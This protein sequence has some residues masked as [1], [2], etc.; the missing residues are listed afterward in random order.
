M[1]KRSDGRYCKQIIIGY[2]DDG[3]R[4]LKNIYGKTK[5]EIEKQEAEIRTQLNSDSFVVNERLTVGEWATE[6]FEVYKANA[7][8]NTAEM[9][10]NAIENHIKPLIGDIALSKLKTVEIQK[11]LNRITDDGKIRTA[12]ICRMTIKQIMRCAYQEKLINRDVSVGIPT[13]KSEKNEK[14]V[15]TEDEIIAL[16]RTKLTPKEQIFIDIMRYMGLRRGEILAL[17]KDDIDFE[18]KRVR[19]NRAIYFEKNKAKVK[20]PKSK[21]GFREIPIPDVL[22]DKLNKYTADLD[23]DKLFTMKTGDY[24]SKQSFRVFW[25]KIVMKVTETGNRLG[26]EIGFTPHIFRHT[27]AT[28]LYYAGVDVKTASYLM[29][30]SDIGVTL[31]IYTHLESKHT[32]AA[33]DKI[34][35][36]NEKLVG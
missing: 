35:R 31:K 18:V 15:L 2:T 30:H 20:N 33:I 36:Y 4:K 9:Y 14:R 21:A 8:Y 32:D 22:F 19:I 5:R 13:I 6:W 25:N 3:R 12:N 28:N 24:M 17:T 1:K 34:N 27:Y 23:T 10:R 26:V 29:G 11:M 7:E 16:S